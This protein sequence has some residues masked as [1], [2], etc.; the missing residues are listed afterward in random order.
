MANIALTTAS[1]VEIV[2][3]IEQ[4]TA[5]CAESITPGAPVRFDTT[6]GTFTNSNGTTTGE[7]DVYGIATGDKIKAAGETI[8]AVA[9]GI[10]D[11][12]VLA[13]NF[14]SKVYLS[15]TDGRL[16]DAAGTVSTVVGQVV[17][18]TATTRGV[19]YDKLLRVKL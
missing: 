5:P 15:D 4:L 18:G 9:K 2:Q 12:F 11:G 17:P 6:A 13:G 19:A 7:A 8:T 1:R 16:A 10:L 14:S 3:S